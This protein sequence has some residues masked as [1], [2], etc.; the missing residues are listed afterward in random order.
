MKATNRHVVT[1]DGKSPALAPVYT[2]DVTVLDFPLTFD[3]GE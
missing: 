1:P 3:V 2:R